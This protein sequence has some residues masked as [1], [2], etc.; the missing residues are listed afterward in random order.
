MIELWYRL[1]LFAEKQFFRKEV[2]DGLIVPAHLLAYYEIAMPELL[3]D[4]KLPFFIDPMSYVWGLNAPRS[5]GGDLKKSFKK[6]AKK[7]DCELANTLGQQLIQTSKE[8]SQEFAE[9]ISKTIQCQLLNVSTEEDP[10]RQSIER[11]KRFEEALG[12]REPSCAPYALIPPYFYFDNVVGNPY[13]KT[14][15]AAQFARDSSLSK[16]YRI[17]PCLCMDATVLRDQDQLRKVIADFKRYNGINLWINDFD[18]T[19]ANERELVDFAKFVKEMNSQG[20]EVI[21]LYGGYFS[22]M[23]SYVGMSKLSCGICYSRSKDVLSQA[24]GGGLP[25]RYYEPH[26]RTKLTNE[27]MIRLYSDIPELFSCECPVCSEYGRKFKQARNKEDKEKLLLEFFG[28][29]EGGFIDW[30]KSR[31]HFL[32]CQKNEQEQLRKKTVKQT[33]SD[34]R[35]TYAFLKRKNFDTFKYGSYEHL[36]AW[37]D[38]LERV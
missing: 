23:L 15:F 7:L 22:L 37:A 9:F 1:N 26:V 33:L 17:Y 5:D 18:E 32:Y 30:E 12:D 11:I 3:R 36:N 29:P 19:K 20:A 16:Q 8:N 24:S 34:L 25:L 27:L 10:R 35:D 38:C 28:T 14:L 31:L 13:S 4:C 2:A 6:L 21:N